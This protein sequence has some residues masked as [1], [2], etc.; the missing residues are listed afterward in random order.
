MFSSGRGPSKCK[1]P[2]AATIRI[3]RE[4]QGGQCSW[5]KG[6]KGEGDRRW[7]E[8]MRPHHAG[9]RE[10]TIGSHRALNQVFCVSLIHMEGQSTG[11]RPFR[12]SSRMKNR[13]QNKPKNREPKKMSTK[14]RLII[15]DFSSIT[16]KEQNNKQE[17]KINKPRAE[18][19]N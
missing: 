11:S 17:L 9:L 4:W 8:R 2:E 1:G 12:K 3:L 18:Q 19:G 14:P 6:R 13:G 10:D 15:I 16:R 7:S 5:D